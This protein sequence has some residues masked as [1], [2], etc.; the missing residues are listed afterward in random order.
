MKHIQ[1]LEIQALKDKETLSILRI[2]KLE[3]GLRAAKILI[4]PLKEMVSDGAI[5]LFWESRTKIEYKSTML[6]NFNLALK[7]NAAIEAVLNPKQN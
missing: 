3:A 7:R 1:Q 5:D 6:E 4:P 2:A